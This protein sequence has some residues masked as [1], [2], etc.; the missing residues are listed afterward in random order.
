MEAVTLKMIRS[1]LDKFKYLFEEE[2]EEGV[3]IISV[4]VGKKLI[5]DIDELIRMGMFSSRSEFIRQAIINHLMRLAK[6]L[7]ERRGE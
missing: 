4:R 1:Q 7:R 6:Y 5:N 3:I 2:E